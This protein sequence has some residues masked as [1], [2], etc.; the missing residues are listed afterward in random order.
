MRVMDSFFPAGIE[1]AMA[2]HAETGVAIGSAIAHRGRMI[3]RAHNQRVHW[4]NAIS[5]AQMDAPSETSATSPPTC[6]GRRSPLRPCRRAMC[7][8]A[9][10]LHGIAHVIGKKRTFLGERALLRSPGVAMKV[11]QHPACLE[12]MRDFNAA[13]PERSDEDTGVIWTHNAGRRSTSSEAA[14]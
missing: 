8:G 3:R 14:T 10:L 11:R 1:E 2:A 5:H 6:I 9:V 13:N 12:F 4:G 7:S